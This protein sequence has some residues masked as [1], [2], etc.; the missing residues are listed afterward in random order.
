MICSS[1]IFVLSLVTTNL[2]TLIVLKGDFNV[3]TESENRN[4]SE[5]L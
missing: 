3:G 4:V 1:C 2:S 5:W